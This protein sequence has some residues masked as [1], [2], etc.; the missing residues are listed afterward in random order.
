MET[1]NS[2]PSKASLWIGWI[3]SGLCILFLLFDAIAKIIK[4][5][6]SVKGSVQLG[7][8]EHAIQGIGIAL[9][10]STILYLIPRTSILG[11]ILLTGYL[12]GAIAIMIR[13]E[14]QLY[15]ASV[16]GLLV[17][18]GLYLRDAELRKIIP[19]RM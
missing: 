18:L 19:L 2:T 3:I 13:A 6:H 11:A 5:E 9:L 7:W 16:F 4:E 14:Q 15:F 10:I 1:G 8:P 12:G 17:W